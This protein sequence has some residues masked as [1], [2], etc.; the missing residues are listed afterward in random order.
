[1]KYLKQFM[2][3]VLFSFLGELLNKIIPLPIPASIYGMVLLFIA[4]S[5]NIIKLEQIEESANFLLSIML[6]MFVPAGVG[7]MDTFSAYK[8]AMFPILVIIITSTII[9]MITTGYVTE[10]I[11]KMKSEKRS[12]TLSEKE[13]TENKTRKEDVLVTKN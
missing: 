7:I 4:L 9:V 8:S 3:I 12:T 2:Y 10:F 5:L 6:I 11:T 13:D 1:M